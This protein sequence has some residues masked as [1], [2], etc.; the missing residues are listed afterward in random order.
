MEGRNFNLL[1]LCCRFEKLDDV[2][3]HA[4]SH[5]EYQGESQEHIQIILK[6]N[7][8]KDLICLS[9]DAPFHL[10]FFK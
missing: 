1:D 4:S 2:S 9:M 7:K 6:I 10:H 3:Q 8:N 5:R